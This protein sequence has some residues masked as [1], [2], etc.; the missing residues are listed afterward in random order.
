MTR[1]LP[2][3]AIAALRAVQVLACSV[4]GAGIVWSCTSS[5]QQSA[6]TDQVEAK[7]CAARADYKLAAA[8]AAG[9]LDPA[10][11][12]PRAKLEAIEDG[13]CLA[14]EGDGGP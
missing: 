11:G 9:R 12:S 1:P 14:R 3:L 13:I 4:L 8:L 2:P 10:P 5:T 6:R 7:L